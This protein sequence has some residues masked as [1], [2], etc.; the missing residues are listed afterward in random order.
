MLIFHKILYANTNDKPFLAISGGHGTNTALNNVKNGIGILMRGM[1]NITIVDDGR[2]ALIEGGILN[3][4]IMSYLWPLGKQT[5]TTG[6]DCVGYIS[7]ILGGG[8]GWFQGNASTLLK[9]FPKF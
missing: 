8:H 6:C 1:D 2:A 7:P 3:G 5:M 9:T 4:D